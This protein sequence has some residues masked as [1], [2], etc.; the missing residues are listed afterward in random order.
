[1]RIVIGPWAHFPWG[2]RVGALDFS[3]AAIGE[4]DQLQI[5]WFDRWLKGRDAAIP[6]PAI[7][8]F[9][10]GALC[11]REFWQWPTQGFTLFAGGSGRAALD[12]RDGT[13]ASTP[14]TTNGHETLVHDPWRPAPGV[15]AALDRASVDARPDVLT[16][17]G[18]AAEA[19]TLLAGNVR[20]ALDI[21]ADALDFDVA[22]TLSR[23]G[24]TGQVI[25]FAEGYRR[26]RGPGPVDVPMRATCLTL[27]SG[28]RLRLSI[29][30]AA[31]PAFPVNP[32]T[33]EDPTRAKTIDARVITLRVRHGSR[34]VVGG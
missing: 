26:V 30:A 23:V 14:P 31:F 32:G 18:P 21:A 11:W 10:M 9:D 24:P 28:E 1:L 13:L 8:L 6:E 4:I 3:E 15:G 33:G 16:F 22:C 2:R 27:Q 5:Q 20:A 25:G 17:T 34:V 29:A 19:P 12:E 7:K